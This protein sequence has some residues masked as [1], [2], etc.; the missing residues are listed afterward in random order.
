MGKVLL[1]ELDKEKPMQETSSLVIY[2]SG[3]E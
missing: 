3:S 2:Q 1:T